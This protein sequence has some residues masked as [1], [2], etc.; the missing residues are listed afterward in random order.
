MDTGAVVVR[1]PR[2]SVRAVL[3]LVATGITLLLLVFPGDM[4]LP[5]LALTPVFPHMG[6]CANFLAPLVALAFFGVGILLSFALIVTGIVAIVL[7]ALQVRGGSAIAVVLNAIVA[8][9][10][11]VTPLSMGSPGGLDQGMLGLAVLTAAAA[12]FPLAGTV[13]LSTRSLYRSSRAY[14]ATLIVAVVLLLPGAAGLTVLALDLGGIGVFQT[15]TTTPVGQ[16]AN[17]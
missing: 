13:L 10:L 17:C 15:V 4:V 6:G 9:L 8:T 14:V 3:G 11:L 7:T 16:S 2:L 5:L 1:K 12:V